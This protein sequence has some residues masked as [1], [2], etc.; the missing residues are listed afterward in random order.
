[1][2]VQ[3][4]LFMCKKVTISA[5]EMGLSQERTFAILVQSDKKDADT[6][7]PIAAFGGPA[8]GDR[9]LPP[10]QNRKESL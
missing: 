10:N 9:N 8:P 7:V 5:K 1:M 4:D 2:L 6:G 3:P